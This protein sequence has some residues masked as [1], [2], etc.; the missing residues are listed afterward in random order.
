MRKL[1]L[2]T[3][4]LFTAGSVNG[5][6]QSD[7]LE[8]LRRVPYQLVYESYIDENWELFRSRPDGSKPVNLTQSPDAHELYPQ[9]SPDRR[10]IAYV[11]DQGAGRK[12]VRSVCYLD[13]A[14]GQR[15]VV[16]DRARQPFWKPPGKVL[17]YLPQEYPRFSVVDYATKGLIYYDLETGESRAHPN[18][19]NLHH[20]YNPSFSPDGRWIVAT[21]HAGMGFDHAILMIEAEGGRIIN[22][23]IP[24]CRPCFSPDGQ[25]IAWGPGDHELAVAPIDWTGQIPKVGKK[26]LQILDQQFK[27]Y[28]IDWSPDGRYLSFSRGPDG[29]G[30]PRKKGT[31]R[32]ACEIVGVYAPGWNLYVTE[33]KSGTVDLSKKDGAWI[34][35]TTNGLSNKE[36]AWLHAPPL[37]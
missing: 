13:L 11:S 29:V 34:A 21:V 7:L 20:L 22:L 9:V 8:Q 4:V 1:A 3:I 17:A 36:S 35:A 5:S 31:H 10:R 16:A 24:G 27:I 14:T 32:A 28:H 18:S 23:G 33:T 26:R 15:T 19:K 30:N 12:T 25:E 2:L 6:D 37:R